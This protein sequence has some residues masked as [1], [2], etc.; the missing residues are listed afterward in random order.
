MT[1]R[2]IL[3]LVAVV[4][5]VWG[6]VMQAQEKPLDNAEIIK[7]VKLEMGDAVVIAKIKLAKE[8][9]FQTATD[10]L[11]KLKE[12][13]VS[14]AVI[15]AML[16]RIVPAPAPSDRVASPAAGASRVTLQTKDGPFDLQGIYGVIK[17]EYAFFGMASWVH[18]NDRSAKIR[19]RDRRPAVLVESE[20][21]PRGGWWYV[22]LGQD[23]K[24]GEDY[25]YF[26]VEGGVMSG[27]QASSAPEKG[28]VVKCDA[29]Q[30]GPGVWRLTPTKDLNPGEYGVFTAKDRQGLVFDFGIDR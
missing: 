15:A 22:K 16:E 1:G 13:G 28:S 20:N 5:L 12:A 4:A 10:D 17:T 30:A 23:K 2:M 9:Q 14:I 3:P 6:P 29:A 11:V 24:D 21:D 19:T 27:F 25:R 18:F 7:L 26:D 8:V